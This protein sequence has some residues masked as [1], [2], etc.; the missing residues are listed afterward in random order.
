MAYT[1][2]RKNHFKIVSVE[3]PITMHN[4]LVCSCKESGLSKSELIR[5]ALKEYI[6]NHS[7]CG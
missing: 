4:L 7:L 1:K 6:L 5:A 2:D 3:L